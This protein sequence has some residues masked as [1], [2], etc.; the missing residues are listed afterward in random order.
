MSKQTISANDF[1]RRD[2][3][4]NI[5]L[6]LTAAGAGRL[7]PAAAQEVHERVK[8]EKA[9]TGGYR[10]KL[11]TEHE[12]KTVSRLAELIVPADEGG[13]SAV[14][15]GAPEFIDLLCSQNEELADIYTGGIL[16]LDA[17]MRKRHG[18]SFVEASEQEQTGMLDLLVET[19]GAER[20]RKSTLAAQAATGGVYERFLYYGVTRPSELG[21]GVSFFDWVRKMSVD[22]YYTSE[23]GYQ[24]VGYMGNGAHS[25]YTVPQEAIDYA[26]SRS[27]FGK[28]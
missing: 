26:L 6:A 5:A 12:W 3:L 7:A 19:E 14:D 20:E 24:D 1:S 28:A 18:K 27:P 21:P 17:R 16:W 8:E 9:E 4:R 25:E 15:A 2:V 22:A 11:F 10:P 23:M 13:G